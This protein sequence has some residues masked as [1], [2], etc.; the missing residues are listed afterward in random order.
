MMAIIKPLKIYIKE[1][2]MFRKNTSMDMRILCRHNIRRW[3]LKKCSHRL[4]VNSFLTA[5]VLSLPYQLFS[6][7][8]NSFPAVSALFLLH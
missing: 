8:F 6:G 5:L 4:V 3:Y 7:C 2:D 1:E